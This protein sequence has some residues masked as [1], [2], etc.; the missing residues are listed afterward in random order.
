MAGILH[1][2]HSEAVKYVRVV[3]D[4]LEALLEGGRLPLDIAATD[5]ENLVARSLYVGKVVLKS[6]LHVDLS[7]EDL[8]G[9]KFVLV[10]VL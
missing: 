1:V 7:A 4:N 9:S 3:V 8:L 2:V 6:R 5:Q 10:D